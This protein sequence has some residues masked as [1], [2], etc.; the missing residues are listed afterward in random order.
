MFKKRKIIS[1]IIGLL[2]LLVMLNTVPGLKKG[3]GNFVYKIFS[4]INGLFIKTGNGIAGFFE[5]L[6]SIHDLNKEN[7][8][9]RQEIQL[10]EADNTRL[11]EIEKENDILKE[12]LNISQNIRQVKEVALISG[13]DIQ[14]FQDW[15]LINRGSK[16]GISENMV[17]LSPE[18]AL[19]GK[20]SEVEPSFSKVMLII[21][22]DSVVAALI[23][24]SRAEGLIKR[25]EKGDLSM[26]F[27]SNTE[28]IEIGEKII[29][30]G[31]DNVY[32]K[33]ILIGKIEVINSSDNQLFQK[34][35]IVPAVNFN[36]LE[37]VIVI[38]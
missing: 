14:G 29:T 5:V 32:P 10:L 34:I 11:K 37:E 38:K 36:K 26:D 19:V 30:S 7:L 9:F 3:L 24:K 8:K 20:I 2:I 18:G 25:S 13:K 15:I 33:G 23:E 6:T 31:M 1:I 16:H 27:I 21:Y 22:R 12:A 4:P 35:F 28:K 17:V